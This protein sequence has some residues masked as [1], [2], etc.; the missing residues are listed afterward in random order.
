VKLASDAAETENKVR[1]TFGKMAKDVIAWSD[2]SLERMGIAQQGAQ[3]MASTFGLLFQ[4]AKAPRDEIVGMSQDFTQLA[5]DM[6]SFFNIPIQEALEVLR[7]GLVGET[8]PLRRFG[9]LLSEAA[10]QT[11]AV[12]IGLAKQG[13]ELTDQQKLMARASL[14]QEGLTKA[15]GDY[16]RTSDAVA[17]RTRTTIER[18]KEL[19]AELGVKLL[20]VA[21]RFLDFISD[22]LTRFEKLSPATQDLILKIAGV[23]AVFGP[24][25]IVIGKVARG[26]TALA[27]LY[28]TLTGATVANTAAT[29]ANAAGQ[30]SLFGATT[31]AATGFSRFLRTLGL[32]GAAAGVV[33]FSLDAIAKEARSTTDRFN[34]AASRSGAFAT[35]MER[36]AEMGP[37]V[38]KGI[39][40]VR[41]LLGDFADEVLI[42]TQRI[43][44]MRTV[45][46]NWN[47]NLS[48]NTRSLV[49]AYIASG[50][51]AS[52]ARVL[53][54]AIR[55]AADENE[56]LDRRVTEVG[57]AM[58]GAET[59]AQLYNR[60][61]NRIPKNKHTRVTMDTSQARA[62]LANLLAQLNN[63]GATAQGAAI[64]VRSGIN[65]VPQAHDGGDVAR[66]GLAVIHR[67]ERIIPHG[68]TGG[69]IDIHLD[70]RRFAGS[71]GYDHTYRGW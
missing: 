51:Y 17:N 70:R 71:L 5:A 24:L 27:G 64:A 49:N 61:L 6:S 35:E 52:A 4:A 11:E 34:E 46:E 30:L 39:A 54:R 29:Q 36:V 8:E 57:G 26:I 28:T 58:R 31:K 1:V 13:E 7:S 2:T 21:E 59:R 55:D 53:R 23:A 14:I 32:V 16:V 67:G 68:G 22:L 18:F 69:R 65:R 41:T 60:E 25:L 50:D 40:P 42:G 62:A 63:I 15:Q 38:G 45:L 19:G 56:N 66:T 47:V 10:V 9:V 3:E 20:P 44:D 48:E 37:F 12:R 43:E 33:A